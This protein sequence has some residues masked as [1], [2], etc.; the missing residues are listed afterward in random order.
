MQIAEMLK[1]FRI[2]IAFPDCTPGRQQV[3][4]YVWL[5]LATTLLSVKKKIK[6]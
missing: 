2:V 6:K 3:M 5:L 4:Q 1:I